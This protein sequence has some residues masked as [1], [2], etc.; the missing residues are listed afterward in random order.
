MLTCLDRPKAILLCSLWQ[1]CL[2]SD[3]T[4]EDDLSPKTVPGDDNDKNSLLIGLNI[5][6]TELYVKQKGA[7]KTECL[8]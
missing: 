4:N 7:I 8:E 3:K 1:A 2:E 5:R 6:I